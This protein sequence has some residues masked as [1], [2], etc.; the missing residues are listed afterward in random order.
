MTKT[1]L[2]AA[3]LIGL[4]A[5]SF[6]QADIAPPKGLRRVIVDHKITTDRDFPDYQFYLVYGQSKVE[7]VQ[8]GSKTPLV[9]P[10]IGRVGPDRLAELVAVP[11]DAA[12][13]YAGV[14]D[15]HAAIA[16]GKVEGMVKGNARFSPETTLKDTDP[17]RSVMEEHKL[18]KL[19]AKEGL[20]IKPIQKKPGPSEEPTAEEAETGGTAYTPRGGVLIAGLAATLAVVFAGLWLARRYR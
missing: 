8:L 11:K 12:K 6:A 17:R 13:R 20:V 9:I 14:K 7:A 19:D 5:A 1:G 4:I 16:A 3:S 2:L 18:E 10:G 15:F